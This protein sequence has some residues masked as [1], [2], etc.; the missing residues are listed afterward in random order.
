MSL[1]IFM[2]FI[3]ENVVIHIWQYLCKYKSGLDVLS[4][5]NHVVYETIT[6]DTVIKLHL[7]MKVFY[8][9]RILFLSII[10]CPLFWLTR[11]IYKNETAYFMKLSHKMEHIKI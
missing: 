2:W 8:C 5:Y 1:D 7:N 3:K 9:D 6:I 11:C 10:F 4:S